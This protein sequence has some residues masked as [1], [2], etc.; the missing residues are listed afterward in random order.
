MKIDVQDSFGKVV[1]SIK[2]N[3]NIFNIEV[4][5]YVVRGMQRDRDDMRTTFESI[6]IKGNPYKTWSSVGAVTREITRDIYPCTNKWMCID[7]NDSQIFA[8]H[9]EFAS[10]C[11]EFI[12]TT[13]NCNYL[14]EKGT[15]PCHNTFGTFLLWGWL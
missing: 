15:K 11:G 4:N 1:E 12:S 6:C 2:L 3:S 5:S 7:A 14:F 8:M 13:W 10:Q 9:K